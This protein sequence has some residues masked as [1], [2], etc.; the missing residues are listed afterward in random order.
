MTPTPFVKEPAPTKSIAVQL[1]EAAALVAG[2]KANLDKAEEAKNK[3]AAEYE[4]SKA[5]VRELHAKF[6]AQFADIVPPP[7]SHFN[8]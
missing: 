8:P 7:A 4:A 1:E 3:A 6:V 2:F 5:K